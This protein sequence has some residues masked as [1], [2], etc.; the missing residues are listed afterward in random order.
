[1]SGHIYREANAYAE[2]LT[3]HAREGN[4]YITH[5]HDYIKQNKANI[6]CIR[7]CWDG[8]VSRESAAGGY[9]IEDAPA[10]GP[11]TL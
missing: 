2:E 1:M 11:W 4:C 5:E 10:N 9:W 7:G 8:G 3:H 6:K